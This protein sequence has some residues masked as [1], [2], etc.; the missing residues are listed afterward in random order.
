VGVLFL[1]DMCVVNPVRYKHGAAV[2][3]SPLLNNSGL[4]MIGRS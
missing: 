2:E 3:Y 4:D 1:L